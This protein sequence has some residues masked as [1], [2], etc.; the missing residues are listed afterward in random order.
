MKSVRRNAPYSDRFE[1][2][3]LTI[4]YEG[5]DVSRGQLVADPKSVDQPEFIPS[6]G[7]TQ[8]GKF[9]AA[10]QASRRGEGPTNRVR[11]YEKIHQGIGH[12]TACLS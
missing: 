6:G 4:I 7:V 11:V 9:F 2:D 12:T 1:D 3:G 5:H 10:A 8:N